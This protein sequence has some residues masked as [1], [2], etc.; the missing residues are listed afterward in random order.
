MKCYRQDRSLLI[1]NPCAYQWWQWSPVQQGGLICK[2]MTY[3]II[4][5]A[6]LQLCLS[7]ATLANMLPISLKYI[8]QPFPL[9]FY[10][11]DA[12]LGIPHCHYLRRFHCDHPNHMKSQSSTWTALLLRLRCSLFCGYLRSSLDIC[13]WWWI[14]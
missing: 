11:P 14:I 3:N 10:T 1:I 6:F 13:A 12:C 2:C 7:V 5:I 9:S 4:F 8:R